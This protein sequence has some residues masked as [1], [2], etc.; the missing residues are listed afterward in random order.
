[1]LAT[2]EGAVRFGEVAVVPQS[3]RVAREHLIWKHMLFDE[4]DACHIALGL[5]DPTTIEGG[6]EMTADERQAAGLNTS[7][8][9]VDFVVGSERLDVFGVH[10][11][12]SER[13]LLID[14]EWAFEI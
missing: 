6:L 9:H 8:V 12:G 1:M 3:S 5:G 7:S 13:S 4:N 14:G 2:D 10:A 11:D